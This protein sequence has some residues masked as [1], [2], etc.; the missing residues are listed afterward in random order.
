MASLHWQHIFY[1]DSWTGTGFFPHKKANRDLTEN[2]PRK[3]IRNKQDLTEKNQE[4]SIR[5]A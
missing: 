2:E 5:N 4:K 3:I 1:I